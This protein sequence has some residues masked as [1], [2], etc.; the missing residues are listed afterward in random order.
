MLFLDTFNLQE[1]YTV[2]L[3]RLLSV[4]TRAGDHGNLTGRVLEMNI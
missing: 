4:S 3:R 1:N 2:V